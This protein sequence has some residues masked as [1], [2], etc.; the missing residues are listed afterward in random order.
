MTESPVCPH[1]V[2]KESF[3]RRVRTLSDT[4]IIENFMFKLITGLLLTAFIT[5]CILL[6]GCASIGITTIPRESY[7]VTRNFPIFV[8]TTDTIT[9]IRFDSDSPM[10]FKYRL[11][12][13]PIKEYLFFSDTL[14]IELEQMTSLMPV[15]VIKKVEFLGIIDP[16]AGPVSEM[17]I[18]AF[19][20]DKRFLFGLLGG[21]AGNIIGY[22]AGSHFGDVVGEDNPDIAPFVYMSSW[23]IGTAGGAVLSYN[24]GYK[25]DNR[26]ALNKIR[27]QRLEYSK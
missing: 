25:L 12:K 26:Y 6:T 9:L 8:T 21:L 24:L 19:R 11:H 23:L 10:F 1:H 7:P 17:E 18:E 16:L 15:S 13:T 3:Y 14:H 5:S 2:Q 27:Q 22:S 4:L 20:G